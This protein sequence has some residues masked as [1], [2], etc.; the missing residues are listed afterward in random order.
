MKEGNVRS[1]H[2]SCGGVNMN[3]YFQSWTV[4]MT[5]SSCILHWCCGPRQVLQVLGMPFSLATVTNGIAGPLSILM[6]TTFGWLTDLGPRPL[7][8]KMAATVL[9]SG[10]LVLA[11][12][13]V[14]TANVIHLHDQAVDDASSNG[15]G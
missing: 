6:L 3:L 14:V 7:C 1:N 5:D 9:Y 11:L 12:V 8:R 4:P 10:I 15:T 13:C 2:D